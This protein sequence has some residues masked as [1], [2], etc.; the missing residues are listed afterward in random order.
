MLTRRKFYTVIN[1]IGLSFGLAI[2]LLISLYVRFELSYERD[3]PLAD[4]MV[5]VTMDY[6][7]G[8]D[9]TDQDAEVYHPLGP[10]ILSEFSE[11]ENFATAYPLNNA[12]INI[13]NE[14]FRE[15]RIYAVTP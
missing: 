8:D 12:T 9:I 11:V 7:N 6:L 10:R 13:R 1:L 3:N 4:R 14:L 15:E 5:R 2:V